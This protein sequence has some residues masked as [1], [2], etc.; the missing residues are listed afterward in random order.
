MPILP[1]NFGP[2]MSF[3]SGNLSQ[4]VRESQGKVR[5]Y[6]L[7]NS[8][9]TLSKGKYIDVVSLYP[10]VTF[11]DKYPI[12]HPKRISKPLNYDPNWSNEFQWRR[13]PIT[14]RASDTLRDWK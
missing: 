1:G 7:C 2:N 14:P 9:A 10:T 13:A 4:R 3:W 6:Y 12:G 5:E 11:Y 8:V